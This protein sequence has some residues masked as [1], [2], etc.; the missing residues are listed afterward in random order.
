LVCEAMLAAFDAL[1]ADLGPTT[2]REAS[3]SYVA[4]WNTRQRI[5]CP[6]TVAAG[7]AVDIPAIGFLLPRY[8]NPSDGIIGQA[9]ALGRASRSLD[10]TPIPGPGIPNIVVA[11]A[12]PVVHSSS[13]EFLNPNTLTNYPPIAAAVVSQVGSTAAGSSCAAPP[14]AGRPGRIRLR[15][16][17]RFLR[18]TDRHRRLDRPRLG[19]LALLLP[20]AAVR[21]GAKTLRARSLLGSR[22]ARFVVPACRS[23]PRTRGRVL[24]LRTDIRGRALRV[25][26][27]GRR[28]ELRLTGRSLRRV[29]ADV[30]VRGR[31]R[32][33]RL[34][35]TTLPSRVGA[36]S[37]RVVGFDRRGEGYSATAHVAS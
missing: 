8:Y 18:V 21:C 25:E 16:P 19:D 17:L 33:V 15:V 29:R 20:G 24:L 37:V 35:T 5:G 13:L 32:R 36:I 12:F 23:R 10:L 6:V 3:S 2:I 34:G 30:R 27:L 9:S 4:G 1:L 14:T 26:R 11:G 31:W 7:T 28:L 22:G